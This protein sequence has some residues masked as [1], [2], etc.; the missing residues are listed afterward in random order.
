MFMDNAL[1]DNKGISK[2]FE[3]K[4]KRVSSAKVYA[5]SPHV[6][7]VPL[8]SKYAP[9]AEVMVRV[10]ETVVS[11]QLISR[12][13]GKGTYSYAP[14]NGVV[15]A[16]KEQK[17]PNGFTAL[18]ITIEAS[19]P[20]TTGRLS[21]SRNEASLESYTKAEILRDLELSGITGMGGAG[22]P[23]HSKYRTQKP[24]DMIILNGAECEPFLYSDELLL[25]QKTYEV[26]LGASLLAKSVGAPRVVVA[27]EKHQKKL[28]KHLQSVFTELSC[29]FEVALV[30]GQY[31]AGEGRLLIRE[32]T[33]NLLEEGDHAADAGALV[34][35]TT[36]AFS[37]FQVLIQKKALTRRYIT[38]SDVPKQKV[39]FLSIP[40][41]ISAIDALRP[42]GL[43]K[44]F[45]T[46]RV[47]FGGPFMGF[48]V[49]DPQTPLAQTDG[50]IILLSKRSPL[51]ENHPCLNCGKCVTAC[52]IGLSPVQIERDLTK[53]LFNQAIAHGLKS[54]FL[55]G[56]CSYA[57]PSRIALTEKFRQGKVS[58][59]K[60]SQKES[61]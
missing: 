35:N 17:L 59:K 15:K 21:P 43:E 44:A 18:V 30:S 14:F 41:G 1:F 51:K 31:P 50:G 29:P 57:C 11:D 16:I 33:G 5:V 55:C 25:W 53:G 56:A 58:L 20:M 24:L 9:S 47:L 22:F 13:Q 61:L 3:K 6:V 37:V 54:C 48:Q 34:S 36:T 39:Y 27:I 23:V 40:I 4:P 46:R 7:S 42:I 2:W 52:P 45:E 60:S 10:G 19:S 28:A 26:L 49:S 32:I 8:T 38:V 12:P